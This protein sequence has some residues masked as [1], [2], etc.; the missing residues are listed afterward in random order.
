[1]SPLPAPAKV[2]APQVCVVGV[3]YVGEHLVSVFA[4]KFQVL[5]YDV[6]PARVNH[7]T[8]VHGNNPRLE[9]STTPGRATSCDL[10]CI[11]VPTPIC[12]GDDGGIDLT[13]LEAAVATVGGLAKPGAAVVIESSVA[14]GTTRR[15]LA[16]LRER[17]L[18]IGF[19]PERVD[20]GRVDPPA[21]VI[22]KVLAAMDKPSMDRLHNLYGAAFDNIIPVS[23]LETAEMSKLFENCFRLVNIAY[24]N[25]IADACQAHGID[26]H[27][28][29]RACA[30]K[31]YGFMP[32]TPGLGAGGPCIPVNPHYLLVNNDLPLLRSAMTTNAA[33]PAARAQALVIKYPAAKRILVSGIGFKPGQA[34]TVHSPGLGLALALGRLGKA[35]TLH[36]PLACAGKNELEGLAVLPPDGWETNALFKAFDLVC[37]AMPQ[38][39]VDFGVLHGFVDGTVEWLCAPALCGP[40]DAHKSLAETA[41]SKAC[42]ASG[43]ASRAEHGSFA[44]V[45]ENKECAHGKGSL[46]SIQVSAVQP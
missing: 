42:V 34:L 40:A 23:T 36:D 30:T 5:G 4:R 12:A 22:P 46:L 24:A 28:M 6:S 38:A 10:F 20:P 7:L 29:V 33:R 19:S 43:L 27:E 21:H 15:L 16:P 35:V 26:P 8:R 14:V 25:E 37:V 2:P 9:L 39:G 3:G 45:A 1:M 31:P 44:A 17:G 41:G 13:Y 18:F 32:F 11:A